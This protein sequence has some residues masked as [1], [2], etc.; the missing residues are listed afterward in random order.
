MSLYRL[1]RYSE[2]NGD[3]IDTSDAL[4]VLNEIEE[5]KRKS[6]NDG[7]D[8]AISLVKDCMDYEDRM[9]GKQDTIVC[10]LE[11]SKKQVNPD[12]D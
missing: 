1:K 11:N 10:G 6:Y 5:I 7:L 3:P 4:G 8:T 2:G 9:L 12:E